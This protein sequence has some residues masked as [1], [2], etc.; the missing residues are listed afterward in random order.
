ML[1]LTSF[2]LIAGAVFSFSLII[3]GV[4]ARGYAQ[5]RDK[6]LDR[7]SDELGAMFLFVDARQV[8]LLNVSCMVLAALA[9]YALGNIAVAA[10]ATAVG[11][12][13]PG[14]LIRYYRRRRVRKFNLQLVD[15]LQSMANAFRAGLTFPQAAEQLA[16]ESLPPLSQELGLMIKELRLGV[17]IDDALINTSQ[18]VRSDD[19]ELVVVATNIA[20]QLGGNMAEMFE[21][22]S[23]TA[24]ERFRLQG[25]IDALTSQGRLQGWIVAAMPLALG[26]VLNYIRPDLLQPMLHHVFGYALVAIVCIMEALGI[27][28]IRRVV[29]IDV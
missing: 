23:A 3:I 8:L 4:L 29:N 24:R 26:L 27:V 11:Y 17:P 12:F 5:Y 10:L 2:L 21:V 1:A 9:G 19:L 13:V 6:Y 20:R 28:L 15:G 18:R 7:S 22:L 25:K 14:F 16:Q